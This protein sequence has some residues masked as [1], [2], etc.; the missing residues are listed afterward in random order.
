MRLHQGEET[1]TRV[2]CGHVFLIREN[3]GEGFVT[4]RT[5]SREIL[6]LEVC[7]EVTDVVNLQGVAGVEVLMTHLTLAEVKHP[8][9]GQLGWRPGLALTVQ[10]A[11]SHRNAHSSVV[12]VIDRDILDVRHLQFQVICTV[13]DDLIVEGAYVGHHSAHGGHVEQLEA[14]GALLD[15]APG[16]RELGQELPLEVLH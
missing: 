6:T 5:H 14:L 11:D 9:P 4:V 16:Y 3:V 13:L 10:F 1:L 12:K 15:F 2:I 8:F 7:L